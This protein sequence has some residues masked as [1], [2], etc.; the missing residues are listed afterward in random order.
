MSR[1]KRDRSYI[2]VLA[3]YLNKRQ[4][5]KIRDTSNLTT[6]VAKRDSGITY[7]IRGVDNGIWVYA[8]GPGGGYAWDRIIDP[9]GLSTLLD[10]FADY[11]V[12]HN[13]QDVPKRIRQGPKEDDY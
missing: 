8:K 13:Y 5:A 11:T 1:H 10:G 2:D 4:A 7:W 9:G 6:L 3:Y 12:L